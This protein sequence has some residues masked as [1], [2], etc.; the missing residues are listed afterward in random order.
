MEAHLLTQHPCFIFTRPPSP[1]RNPKLPI[2]PNL[3]SHFRRSCSTRYRP[4]DSNAEP[5]RS[6]SSRF[7]F[8]D[9]ED[10][11]DDEDQASEFSLGRSRRKKN[12]NRKRRWWSDDYSSSPEMEEESGGIFEEVIDSLW[13]LKVQLL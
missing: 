12:S 10:E 6:S 8:S 7:G 9:T 1:R 11:E 4:W 3:S 5:V 2:T 13:I